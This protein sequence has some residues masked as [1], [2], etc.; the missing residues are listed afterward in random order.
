MPRQAPP[1]MHI[2]LRSSAEEDRDCIVFSLFEKALADCK[3]II[4]PVN[5]YDYFDHYDA[6]L[7]GYEFLRSVLE[8]IAGLN[9][10]RARHVQDFVSH[11]KAANGEA[12][13]AIVSGNTLDDA[14]T[15]KDTTEYGSDFL[16]DAMLHI[17]RLG[18]QE[19]EGSMC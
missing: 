18:T 19:D 13:A 5:V 4:S 3:A 14:F 15:L 6:Q 17:K 12:F 10:I 9:A 1:N 2:V 11:W 16:T 8:Y 7:H